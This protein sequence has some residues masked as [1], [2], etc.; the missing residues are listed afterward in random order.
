MK[1]FLVL[2]LLFGASAAYGEIYT[3][4]DAR[5]TVFYTNSLHEIPARYLRKA[6][7]LDV[8]TG[9]KA[10]L[11][12]AQPSVQGGPAASPGQTPVQQAPAVNPAVSPAGVSPALAS[13]APP[14]VQPAAGV[15]A[16]QLQPKETREQR[17]AQRRRDRSRTEEE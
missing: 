13:P 6:R 2:L 11:A 8:A 3:W 17:R 4:K 15:T 14:P 7:V 10:G 12:T 5:G 1:R 16:P 9:K